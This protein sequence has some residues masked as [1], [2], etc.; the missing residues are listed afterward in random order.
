MKKEGIN[1]LHP[2]SF[3]RSVHPFKAAW[4]SLDAGDND[5]VR[6]WRYV[7]AACQRFAPELSREG[8]KWLR[9]ASRPPWET[10][11]TGLLNDLAALTSEVE[12]VVLVLE[13]YHLITAAPVHQTLTF[14]L[15]H[16]PAT[17]HLLLT[18]RSDPPLPLAQWRAR[19]ELNEL[20]AL[21][22][23]FSREETRLFFQQSLPL[24]LAP[25]AITYLADRTEGWVAG[26]RLAALALQ[27]RP[28]PPA[29]SHFLATFRGSHNH[30]F[31]YLVAEVLHA[32]PDSLQ[33][34]LLQTS[35][36]NRLCGDLC[37][38]VTGRSD[39]ELIL[40]QLERAN[41]FLLPFIDGQRAGNDQGSAATWY[42]YHALFAEAM[43]QAA[44][45]RWGDDEL[46][47]LSHKASLWYEQHG[48]LSE[49]VEAA[50]TSQDF[51]RAAELIER[52]LDP[53]NRN[54]EHHTLRR[55][56]EPL[57]EAVLRTHPSLA[58][59][60]AVAILFT[61]DRRAPTTLALLQT[62]LQVAEA[63]WSTTQEEDKLGGVFALRALLAFLQGEFARAFVHA[64]EALTCLPGDEA[65]WRDV[66]LIF[67]GLEEL[68]AGRLNAAAQTLTTARALCEITSNE[69]GA[70]DA[71]LMLG[72]VYTRQGELHQAAQ[73]YQHVLNAAKNAHME[74]EQALIRISNALIGLS[75]LAYEGNDLEAA[76]Q[77]AT[78]ALALGEQVAYPDL[79]IRAVLILTH[80]DQARGELAAAQQRLHTLL[81]QIA[82][83][84][85][86]VLLRR[87]QTEQA[88]LALAAGDVAA[89]ERWST[90]VA[91]QEAEMTRLQQEQE[92][93]LLA[94]WLIAQGEAED[95]LGLLE[96]WYVEAADEGRAGSR[97]EIL[98][99]QSLVYG[100]ANDLPQAHQAL[101][102]A[103]RLAQPKGYQRLFLD[104]GE[105]LA[106]LL[107]GL[108]SGLSDE[109][110][111]S[112]VQGLL[113]ALGGG[114]AKQSHRAQTPPAPLIEPLSERE[115]DVLKLVAAGLA[116]EEVAQE[117]VISIGT[118]RTHLKHIY[119]KL[120]AHN[121]VQAVERARALNLV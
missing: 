76:A 35:V 36:L 41:L 48:L 92:A 44:R 62:P 45:R 84:R 53:L 108:L 91:S 70:L 111:L 22:L 3:T 12:Q 79:Q 16:L 58:F 75:A 42:R 72:E 104:E 109:P 96:P 63:Q 119:G 23:R 102:E 21:D 81:A 103:L 105:P 26:L 50:L 78:Q 54:Y 32:Q 101:L 73:L 19:N 39:S 116:T 49:A 97:L 65:Q 77:Q 110:L 86:S 38:A 64:K 6:F 59:L 29:M 30:I 88:K 13:D 85:W 71:A 95:C 17:V 114:G 93:L 11:L 43:Q 40:E 10:V 67:M 25:A 18:T 51:G 99:L 107:P 89:L 115:R 37:D 83:P 118:V 106:R 15:E 117:L 4:V 57:P 7:T 100:A 113:A 1:H 80:L 87:V 69:F 34:F 28:E 47:H 121:R 82:E 24:P 27:K 120:D 33:E 20:R 94:R 68:Q 98:V 56:I 66:C 8:L 60:Y 74:R 5:P 2:S 46:H 14:F 52:T 31:T 55:W 90:T 112:Y 61:S 9:T